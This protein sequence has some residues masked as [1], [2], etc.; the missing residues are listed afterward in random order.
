MPRSC[1]TVLLSILSLS[2]LFGTTQTPNIIFNQLCAAENPVE[3]LDYNPNM[4]L[5]TNKGQQAQA[6]PTIYL[7]GFG[8]DSTNFEKYLHRNG[9]LSTPAIFFDFRDAPLRKATSIPAQLAALRYTNI[10]QTRDILSFVYVLNTC[11]KAGYRAIDV[12]GFSRGATTAMNTLASLCSGTHAQEF[13]RIGVDDK[14]REEIVAMLQNGCITLDC[15]L[16]HIQNKFSYFCGTFISHCILPLFTEHR[17]WGEQAIDACTQ[18]KDKK[19]NILLHYEEKDLMVSNTGDRRMYKELRE[20]NPAHTYVLKSNDGGHLSKRAHLP[21]VFH[22]FKQV[23]GHTSH[24]LNTED[25]L[26]TLKTCQPD[27][28]TIIDA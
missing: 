15:P 18:L 14:A 6:H 16:K 26:I 25:A 17:P 1:T 21:S 27:P 9:L 28:S 23:Y 10:G 3:F 2:Y 19:F 11:R 12:F 24:A 20:H 13:A 7:H 4:C 5:V 22:A 8:D